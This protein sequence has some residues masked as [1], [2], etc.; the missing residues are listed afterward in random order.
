SGGCR[1]WAWG[2]LEVGRRSWCM[3]CGPAARRSRACASA[4]MAWYMAM[5]PADRPMV[6][7]NRR[8]GVLVW[9]YWRRRVLTPAASGMTLTAIR[10][11]VTILVSPYLMERLMT[12]IVLFENIHPSAKEVFV[13]SGF[14]EVVTY[15]GAL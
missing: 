15:P 3:G 10:K 6:L 12:R 8:R 9:P 2:L 1:R 4:V 5:A 11:C 14:D 13:A 7:R